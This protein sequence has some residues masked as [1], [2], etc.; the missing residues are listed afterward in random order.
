MTDY[1]PSWDSKRECA[2]CAALIDTKL[3]R[4]GPCL[5]DLTAPPENAAAGLAAARA[6]LQRRD[7]DG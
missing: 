5:A 1:D 4:C 6:A 2:G 3:E 7:A